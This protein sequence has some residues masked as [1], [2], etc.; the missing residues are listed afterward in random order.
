M[1]FRS[2]GNAEDWTALAF[3]L[4][5]SDQAHLIRDFKKIVG[6]TPSEYAKA[7]LR[8]DDAASAAAGARA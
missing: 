4:G 1:L 7:K 3:D 5:Y 8:T 2:E 6:R